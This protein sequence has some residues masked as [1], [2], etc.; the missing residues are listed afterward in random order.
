MEK[1]MQSGSKIV[2]NDFHSTKAITLIA[3]VITI[4][5]LIILVGVMLELTVGKNSILKN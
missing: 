5:I 2:R 3:L 4:I 1:N